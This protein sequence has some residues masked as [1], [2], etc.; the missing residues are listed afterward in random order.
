MAQLDADGGVLFHALAVQG[1]LLRSQGGSFLGCVG[2]IIRVG[3]FHRVVEGLLSRV[4]PQCLR[5][6]SLG[7]DFQTRRRSIRRTST[8][9]H[10]RYIQCTIYKRNKIQAHD[11]NESLYK[12][13]LTGANSVEAFVGSARGTCSPQSEGYV[14]MS[15]SLLR[16]GKEDRCSG[17]E[18]R[19]SDS[20]RD[21]ERF[22][23]G[24]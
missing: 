2:Q 22:S 3:L 1:R 23:F 20:K 14:V 24:Q 18:G 11:R 15:S 17:K 9:D 6:E 16:M 4:R 21:T 5:K 12:L 8:L 19:G 13:Q 10:A 7:R